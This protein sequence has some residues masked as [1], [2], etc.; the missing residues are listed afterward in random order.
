MLGLVAL[1]VE[2]DNSD[3]AVGNSALVEA[4]YKGALVDRSEGMV[5]DADSGL[6]DKAH[7]RYE[8]VRHKDHCRCNS[9]QLHW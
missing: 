4:C 6:E 7:K 1:A 8:E 9:S 5:A 2:Q 3:M